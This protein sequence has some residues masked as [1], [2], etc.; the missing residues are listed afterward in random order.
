MVVIL[1]EGRQ[2][3]V[4]SFPLPMAALSL[5]PS[6]ISTFR[7]ACIWK[8]PK[9]RTA[10]SSSSQFLPRQKCLV[11]SSTRLQQSS[12]PSSSS[13]DQPSSS[14]SASSNSNINSKKKSNNEKSTTPLASKNDNDN[15]RPFS[16]FYK[17][18]LLLVR[19]AQRKA[20]MLLLSCMTKFMAL[21]RRAKRLVLAQ[22]FL[23]M[24]LCALVVG[25]QTLGKVTSSH[26]RLSSNKTPIEIPYSSFLNLLRDQQQQQQAQVPPSP[27]TPMTITNVLIGKE[28]ITFQIDRDAL[29]SP[30]L[31]SATSNPTASSTTTTS[32][33]N[34]TSSSSLSSSATTSKSTR[35]HNKKKKTLSPSSQLATA[36]T[37]HV[38][39][40]PELVQ[41][42]HQHQVPFAAAST[43]SATIFSMALR[44]FLVTFYML[45]LW[46][47][48][49]AVSGKG[50][51]GTSTDSVGKL[52][53][54]NNNLFGTSGD[55]NKPVT[56]D[57]I[58]GIDEAKFQVMELVD[59]LKYP[60][61]YAVLG[62]RAPK[63]LLLEGP[64]G[65]GKVCIET[66]PQH[67]QHYCMTPCGGTG[68]IA[69]RALPRRL[70][71]ISSVSRP[72][73]PC[74]VYSYRP[75]W[76]GRRLPWR[77]FRSCIAVAVTLW[78]CLLGVSGMFGL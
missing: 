50:G 66:D 65:T 7:G 24:M 70:F 72:Y 78:K 35:H 3:L 13:S 48:Y 22:V 16:F 51:G 73:L 60:D 6:T 30:T 68:W 59:A 76:Q 71:C 8:P 61:K 29:Y 34:P 25:P 14:G 26:H 36:F 67:D 1:M 43:Q 63:G 64:P 2:L 57:D 5:R 4:S 54:N 42:L 45:I 46:R 9:R 38:P 19:L 37:R 32:K 40:S 55:G 56:F 77:E 20:L 53:S 10:T 18:P 33:K 27:T 75:C 11:S 52:A 41:L 44:S 39:A 12:T 15:K 23:V 49:R 62:A 47:M 74:F 17:H 58:E 31:L 28:K 21:S 69:T